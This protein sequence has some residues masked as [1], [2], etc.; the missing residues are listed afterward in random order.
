MEEKIIFQDIEFFPIPKYDKYYASRCGQIY[1]GKRCRILTPSLKK[2]G[3]EGITLFELSNTKN[4]RLYPSV[5]SLIA[6]TFIGERPKGHVINHK[7]YNRRN[8]NASNLEYLT[9]KENLAHSYDNRT[10]QKVYEYDL[11]GKFVNE[12]PCIAEVVRIRG[13][14]PTHLKRVLD[15]IKRSAKGRYYSR[16]K[17]DFFK[18]RDSKAHKPVFV[19]DLKGEVIK[20][21]DSVT[22]ASKYCGAGQ[23]EI[24]KCC[25]GKSNTS[26]GFT[27]KYA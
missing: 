21:F 14:E 4:P 10:Y 7:D 1:S 6:A 18:P 16:E 9:Q 26:F 12:Y 8:N 25:K 5:H 19:C 17:L 13:V 11:E 22:E 3:Y 27:F 2:T 24:I 15:G 23:S 20:K